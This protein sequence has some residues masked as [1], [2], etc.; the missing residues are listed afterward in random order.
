MLITMNIS[1]VTMESRSLSVIKNEF[2]VL[3]MGSKLNLITNFARFLN[4]YKCLIE[5]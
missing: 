2:D 4:P 1:L 5:V 3:F